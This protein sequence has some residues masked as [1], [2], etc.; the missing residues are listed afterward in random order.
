MVKNRSEDDIDASFQARNT[1]EAAF[2]SKGAYR[3]LQPDIKGVGQL[4]VHLSQPLYK[5]LKKELPNL[6]AE[7]NA[8][9]TQ[10]VRQLG[11]LGEKRSTVSE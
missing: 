9:H 2:T 1:S 8:K 3:T 11:E 5:H 7:L 4:R 10:T 6:Q